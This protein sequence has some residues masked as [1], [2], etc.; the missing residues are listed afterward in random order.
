MGIEWASSSSKREL[1]TQI[2][3]EFLSCFFYLFFFVLCNFVNMILFVLFH[4]KVHLCIN[5]V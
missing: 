3:Y 5:R 4:T 2:M 1:H